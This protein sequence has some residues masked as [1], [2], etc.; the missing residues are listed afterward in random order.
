MT[1]TQDFGGLLKYYIF[2][3]NTGPGTLCCVKNGTTTVVIN[4]SSLINRTESIMIME[5]GDYITTEDGNRIVYE[6]PNLTDALA[7]GM[8][9]E[10]TG[11]PGSTTI[12][13]ITNSTTFV[14]SAAAT[15][16]LTLSLI[17]I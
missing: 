3:D 14:L 1:T 7:V 11:I 8:L 17:H 4:D 12:A 6:G 2:I 9:V 13:S 16:S 10:G 5:N 15:D